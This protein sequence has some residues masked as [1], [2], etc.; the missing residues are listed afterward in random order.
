LALFASAAGADSAKILAGAVERC[1]AEAPANPPQS[2]FAPFRKRHAVSAVGDQLN[3]Y[4]LYESLGAYR[5]D[6]FRVTENQGRGLQFFATLSGGLPADKQYAWS[7][8]SV[9]R[10]VTAESKAKG[11]AWD[12]VILETEGS[13][14]S[15]IEKVA[16]GE[17][18]T[19][20][21]KAKGHSPVIVSPYNRS[22]L[23]YTLAEGNEPKKIV[24]DAWRY[25][26]GN[27]VMDQIIIPTHPK[28]QAAGSIAYDHVAF[29]HR[30]TDD[31]FAKDAKY[32][33]VSSI[34]LAT[35]RGPAYGF[36][37]DS[38]KQCLSASRI[39]VAH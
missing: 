23:A 17:A 6:A 24:S 30:L 31:L 15:I 28:V 22:M 36:L 3:T 35:N 1:R 34:D 10:I 27:W 20:F 4:S 8:L 11:D 32:M 29:L 5:G 9:P 7:I 38:N 33:F 21:T 25:L 37:I 16:G 14:S 12:A 19:I 39:E 26:V 18:K 2:G 13:F